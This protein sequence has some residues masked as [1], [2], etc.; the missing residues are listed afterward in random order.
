MIIL[1]FKKELAVMKTNIN[2]WYILP[3]LAHFVA[4]FAFFGG[5]SVAYFGDENGIF[6][7]GQ[8]RGYIGRNGRNL[9][10]L[11]SGFSTYSFC[12]FQMPR[13]LL[14]GQVTQG[15][16]KSHHSNLS[17]NRLREQKNLKTKIKLLC[18]P[19]RP[20]HMQACF[21]SLSL[22]LGGQI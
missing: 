13:L 15:T 7:G 5:I 19:A 22:S 16:P 2:G 3:C 21:L 20:L 10:C 8:E 14:H 18:K 6:L 9:F 11:S 12:C 4:Y 1:S 17:Y